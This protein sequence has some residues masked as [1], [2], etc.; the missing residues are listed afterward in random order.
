MK[1]SGY[2]G[3]GLSPTPESSGHTHNTAPTRS[4]EVDGVRFRLPA[5]WQ[6]ARRAHRA[7]PAL[8]GTLDNYDPA[9]TDAFAIGSEVILTDN[10]GVGLSTGAAPEDRRGRRL[11]RISASKLH[12]KQEHAPRCARLLLLRQAVT[13]GA[14]D[15]SA[16]PAWKVASR[17]TDFRN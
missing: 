15:P 14:R 17:R 5:L 4:V 11:P 3:A 7:A 1:S 8:L 9:I 2:G 13:R 6:P 10:A 16:A 12:Q